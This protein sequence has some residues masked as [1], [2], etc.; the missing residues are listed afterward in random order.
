[1]P[2]AAPVADK[3]GLKRIC[4]SCGT[5]FYDMNKR[6]VVCPHCSTEFTGEAKVKTRRSRLP[7]A[8][9]STVSAKTA[10]DTGDAADTMEEDDDM[11]VGLDDVEED[12]DDGDD[13]L[14]GMELDEDGI[15]DLDELEEE[16]DELDEDIDSEE[17][18][19]EDDSRE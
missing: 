15:G 19:E 6:P 17:E 4:M 9:E 1:M 7:A 12:D 8:E 14:E 18:I 5:R 16:D 13:D 2:V 11:V 3:R 10:A